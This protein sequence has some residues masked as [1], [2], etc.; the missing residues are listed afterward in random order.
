MRIF[1]DLA[2]S[3]VSF[4]AEDAPFDS[5]SSVCSGFASSKPLFGGSAVRPAFSGGLG[6]FPTEL[7]LED[8][9]VPEVIRLCPLR[10]GSSSSVRAGGVLS[11]LRWL[12]GSFLA[13]CLS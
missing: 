9:G 8:G 13:L 12:R 3:L 10:C 1:S 2:S 11:G 7:S 4:A 5:S 6:L